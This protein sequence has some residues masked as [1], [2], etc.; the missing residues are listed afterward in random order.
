MS[1]AETTGVMRPAAASGIGW[2]LA[3][4]RRRLSDALQ[5]VEARYHDARFAALMRH[6]NDAILTISQCFDELARV[7]LVEA[8]VIE[9]AREFVRVA[10][11]A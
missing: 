1:A 2:R 4:A 6:A 11:F 8:P 10:R 9:R 3:A 7:G 5:E